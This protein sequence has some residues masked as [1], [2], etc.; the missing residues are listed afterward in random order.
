[1]GGIPVIWPSMVLKLNFWFNEVKLRVVVFLGSGH[2][3]Q[4]EA[5]FEGGQG[6]FC[7]DEAAL[8]LGGALAGKSGF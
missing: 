4:A 7:S 3:N 6:I 1:M 2:A 8:A 5:K